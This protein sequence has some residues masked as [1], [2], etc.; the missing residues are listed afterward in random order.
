M[1]R[2]LAQRL[3]ELLVEA[4]IMTEQQ[5]KEALDLQRKRNTLMGEILIERGYADVKQ[6]SAALRAQYRLISKNLGKLLIEQELITQGQLDEAL[7]LQSDKGGLVGQILVGLGYIREV[8]VVKCLTTQFG[9]PYLPLINYEIDP[10][11]V[12][13][14]PEEMCRQ[15]YL[16]PVDKISKMLVVTMADPL[17]QMILHWLQQHTKFNVE[18]FVSSGTEI[19]KTIDKYY[20]PPKPGRTK[21]PEETLSQIDFFEAVKEED[22][23]GNN[24]KTG[25][26]KGQKKGK[27]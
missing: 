13:L 12:K 20:G 19:L 17:N 25:N 6:I 9:F 5:L 1:A 23:N 7:K 8:D 3:G 4:G 22:K 10:Q 21:T 14:V 2:V 18:T 24:H 11:I 15:Y 26:G 27:T 16:I